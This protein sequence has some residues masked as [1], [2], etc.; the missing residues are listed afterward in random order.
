MLCFLMFLANAYA[1]EISISFKEPAY[2]LNL[3]ERLSLDIKAEGISKKDLE[4]E[5]SSSDENVVAIEKGKAIALKEGNV[6][7]TCTATD[8]ENNSYTTK[9]MI[10]VI[11]PIKKLTVE[12][13]NITLAPC[14]YYFT[15]DESHDG[16]MSEYYQHQV[17]PKIE[18][19]NASIKDLLWE[20]SN[21]FV[22]TVND[23]G[24]IVGTGV[25]K[26]TIT[27]TAKDASKK[28]VKIKV[29]VPHIY[30]TEDELVID[31]P[32]GKSLGYIWG[33]IG[34]FHSYGIATKG[35]CF[36]CEGDNDT[37]GFS[38]LNV[39][40]KK[41]GSGTIMFVHN[42]RAAKKIKVKVMKSALEQKPDENGIRPDFKKTMDDY[43]A[44]I[45]SFCEFM[46]SY[47]PKNDIALLSDYMKMLEDYER[48]SKEFDS[49]DAS[50]L[51][52]A[53]DKYYLDTELYV[54]KRLLEAAQ[55]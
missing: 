34:G 37:D 42:N 44:F 22:A 36:E 40:P 8:N 26:A 55:D 43:K 7:I 15:D 25:G 50:T 17:V 20:S 14:D 54:N 4:I 21:I 5:Y 29:N 35:D 28:T 48:L 19:E 30:T 13:K 3:D 32:E 39:I 33:S 31:S 47:E 18:P 46:E 45:D 2:F 16:S 1:E 52:E 9:C 51:S 38:M 24:L 49:V 23:D 41:E 53:E 12:E 6:T 10:S 11:I 27:G